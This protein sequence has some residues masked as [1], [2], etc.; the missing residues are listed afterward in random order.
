M[1]SVFYYYEVGDTGFRDFVILV[2]QQDV[3]N[4]LVCGKETIVELAIR[5]FVIEEH[6]CTIK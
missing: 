3:I 5:C 4:I 6:L 1:L 2:K